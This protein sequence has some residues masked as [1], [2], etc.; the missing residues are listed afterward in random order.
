MPI[1]WNALKVSEAVDQV[2]QQVALAE[3]FLVE[4]RAKA[5]GVPIFNKALGRATLE[6]TIAHMQ[7]LVEEA[8]ADSF[9]LFHDTYTRKCQYEQAQRGLEES[10]RQ[11]KSVLNGYPIVNYG[12]KSTRRIVESL[13]IPLRHWGGTD[14]DP[15]LAVEMGLASGFTGM[16]VHD[17]HDLMHHSKNYPVDLRI[18]NNQYCLKLISYYIERGAPIEVFSP[19]ALSGWND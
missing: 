17:I 15:R 5:E 13:S 1:R 14:E 10:I 7:F 4:A 2:E 3:S 12:A 8:D 19:G 11:G 18:R 16:G 9:D 6:E